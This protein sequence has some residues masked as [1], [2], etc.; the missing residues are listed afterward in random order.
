MIL[1]TMLL[2][3]CF[4]LTVQASHTQSDTEKEKKIQQDKI[5]EDNTVIIRKINAYW[6]TLKSIKSGFIQTTNTSDKLIEGKFWWRNDGKI[7]FQYNAPHYMVVLGR[8]GV[9]HHINDVKQKVNTSN[10]ENNPISLFL[11]SKLDLEK[12]FKILEI[13]RLNGKI[14]ILLTKKEFFSGGY[15]MLVFLEH[16]LQLLQWHIMDDKRKQIN[17]S[18][19]NS[20]YDLPIEDKYFELSSIRKRMD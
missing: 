20:L 15:I 8:D 1:R 3:S 9:L 11:K 18:L 14:Q 19:V 6:S 4:G 10:I 12:D 5:K 13:K 2:S 17:V 16:P 7:R